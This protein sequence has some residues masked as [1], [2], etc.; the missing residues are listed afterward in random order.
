MYHAPDFNFRYTVDALNLEVYSLDQNTQWGL[1]LGDWGRGRAKQRQAC[2]GDSALLSRL[3]QVSSRVGR[4]PVV[5]LCHGHTTIHPP[6]A[7]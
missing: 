2:G 6:P 3:R 5:D 1:A 4:A 7:P